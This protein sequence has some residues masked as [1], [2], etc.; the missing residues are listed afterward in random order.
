MTRPDNMTLIREEAQ[1]NGWTVT[2]ERPH[3][4]VLERRGTRVWIHWGNLDRKYQT[5]LY[6]AISIDGSH[7]RI[8]AHPRERLIRARGWI[9]APGE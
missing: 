1:A 6:A 8:P 5:C 9:N 4:W 3:E 7:G 2:E